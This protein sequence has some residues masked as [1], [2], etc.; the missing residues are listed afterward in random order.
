[1]NSW[2][3]NREGDSNNTDLTQKEELMKTFFIDLVAVV[4]CF[5][6]FFFLF[7]FYVQVNPTE[8]SLGNR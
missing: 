4:F 1:M 2:K 7:S 3:S 5:S 6:L 8:A